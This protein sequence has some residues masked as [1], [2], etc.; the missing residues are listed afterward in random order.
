MP[1][2]TSAVLGLCMGISH[3]R[4]LFLKVDVFVKTQLANIVDMLAETHMLGPV[5]SFCDWGGPNSWPQLEAG[6]PLAHVD[7]VRHPCICFGGWW[8]HFAWD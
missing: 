5:D 3:M 4:H 1:S 7:A 2:E 8:A 6:V